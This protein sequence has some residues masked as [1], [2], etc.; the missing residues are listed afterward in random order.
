MAFSDFV[1]WLSGGSKE[2]GQLRCRPVRRPTVR[3]RCG[4]ALEPLEDRYAPAVLTVNSLVDRPQSNADPFLTLRDALTIVNTQSTTGLSTGEASQVAGTLGQ[5]DAIIFALGG[6]VHL[7]ASLP[8]IT[9]SV[10]ILGSG[11]GPLTID[12]GGQFQIFAVSSSAAL[13]SIAG[14]TLANGSGSDGGGAIEEAAGSTSIT[15]T[16]CTFAGNQATGEVFGGGAIL[17]FGGRLTVTDSVFS[18]NSAPT[19]GGGAIFSDGTMNLNGDSFIGNSAFTTGF[20]NVTR[21]GGAILVDSGLAAIQNS[22]FTRN[23]TGNIAG[24]LGGAIFER[25]GSA[26]VGN[27]SFTSNSAQI[28][29]AIRLSTGALNIAGSTF[30]ANSATIEG[31]AVSI[32]T[33]PLLTS[34][35]FIVDSTFVNNSASEDGGGLS[36]GGTVQLTN[37][38]VYANSDNFP[39]QFGAGIRVGASGTTLDNTIVAANMAPGGVESDI[40]GETIPGSSYNIIGDSG[41]STGL[42]NGTSGNRLGV[43]PGLLPLG[44]YG[45]PTQTMLP[46][47]GSPAIN[48]GNTA[49]LTGQESDQ[50]GFNRT[51]GLLGDFVDIGAVEVQ[52]PGTAT[53]LQLQ[54][55]ASVSAG[56]VM[57]FSAV[58]LD[59]NDVPAVSD[60]GPVAVSV[61]S[62][63]GA[64]TT[65]STTVVNSVYGTAAFN[66]LTLDTPG[67]YTV[68]ASFGNSTISADVLVTGQVVF[69]NQPA[70]ATAGTAILGTG[71]NPI[72]VAV[73]DL[74]GRPVAG[75][76][77]SITLTL[78]AAGTPQPFSN[79]QDTITVPL[80]NGVATLSDLRVNQANS[81]VL[82]VSAGGEILV[83]SSPFSVQPAAVSQL[84]FTQQP[85]AVLAG[86]TMSPAV[87]VVA[88]DAF[89]NM[90]GAGTNNKVTLTL[91]GPGGPVVARLVGGDVFTFSNLVFSKAGTFTLS[92]AYGRGSVSASSASFTV[93]APLVKRATTGHVVAEPLSKASVAVS[94]VKASEAA[95]LPPTFGRAR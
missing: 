13:V 86:T 53:H 47:A 36:L 92:A 59:D 63:P 45:G 65:S 95:A 10:H 52:P 89:G 90:A 57:S 73:E 23:S 26:S 20:S 78:V 88:E 58:A 22:T 16:N 37:D 54:G 79:G 6:T 55:P 2:G 85:S 1:R 48:A 39:G 61:A 71:K 14:L 24:G 12:G 94:F 32:G 35:A 21:G 72:S 84:V 11:A 82:E 91:N 27:D 70:N 15:V 76:N 69:A 75:D 40:G 4:L 33:V 41:S 3:R 46:A 64:F 42:T 44:N 56:A 28:G 67:Y 34:S 68:Q 18:G 31:G 7:T 49:F 5:N 93:V 81:Y 38:T 25:A 77:G 19:S 83:S 17:S 30:A 80:V 74:S 87:I 9:A 50:R 51:Y 60:F 62:G 29:G 8:A 66:N 43:N